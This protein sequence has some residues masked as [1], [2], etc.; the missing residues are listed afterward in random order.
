MRVRGEGPLPCSVC[1]VGE[2]PGYK[3]SETGRPFVG[4][5][6]IELTRYLER[7]W[8]ERDDIYVTNLVK[9][10]PPVVNGKQSAPSRAD[11]ER[12]AP[13]LVE[14]LATAQPRWIGAVGRVAAQWL[15]EVGSMEASHGM[16]FPLRDDVKKRLRG[17][18]IVAA[19][20]AAVLAGRTMPSGRT[21][22]H[23]APEDDAWIDEVRVVP[24]HHPAAALHN[25][26][27]QPLVHWDVQQFSKYVRGLLTPVVPVDDVS[28]P[29]YR[30]GAPGWWKAPHIDSVGVDTEGSVLR[31][32]SVQ[33]SADRGMGYVV[34]ADDA[35]GLRRV[36]R[37][38][39]VAERIVLQHALHDVDVLAAM[40]LRLDWR[41]VE[42]TYIAADVLRLVPRGLKAGARRDCGMEMRSYQEVIAPAERRLSGEWVRG[43]IEA[44]RCYTCWG[45]GKSVDEL[46]LAKRKAGRTYKTVPEVKC[47]DCVDG[48]LWEPRSGEIEYDWKSG[49]YAVR[50][51]WEVQRYLR[52]LEADIERG[53]FETAPL[54]DDGGEVEEADSPRKRVRSWPVE[55]RT[56]LEAV[57][58]PLPEPTLSDVPPDEAT[59]YACLSHDSLVLTERGPQKIGKLV[60]DRYSGHVRS[61]DVDTGRVIL[62]PVTGWYKIGGTKN[63]DRVKWLSVRTDLSLSGRWGQLVSRYT[64]DHRLLS[65]DGWKRVDQLKVG[66]RIATGTEALSTVEYQVVLGSVL[67]D[68]SLSRRNA[69][70]GAQFRTS[71]AADQLPY[72]QWKAGLFRSP[73]PISLA[74]PGGLGVIGGRQVVRQSHYSAA[75][76][77]SAELL[78]LRE[79]AYS[80][81][82][83]EIVVEDW[84]AG[85]LDA[86][87]L[88]VWYQDDGTLVDDR[89]ARI[90]TLA[91]KHES[92]ERLRKWLSRRHTV[93]SAT[94]T[95]SEP[96]RFGG[97]ILTTSSERFFQII[98]QYVHPCMRYKL[99]EKYRGFAF[100]IA[101]R[102]QSRGQ[103]YACVE[104][105]YENPAPKGR[106]GSVRTSYCIDVADTHNFVTGSGEVAHNC[107]D[108]DATL[109]RYPILR[110]QLDELGLYDAYRLDLDVMPIA[111]EMQRNGMRI[112]RAYFAELS[113]ELKERKFVIGQQLRELVGRPL[114]PGSGDQ[115]AD[116]LYGRHAASFDDT[117]ERDFAALLSFD[118]APE[119]YTRSGKRGSTDDKTLEGLKL[120]YADV[121]DIVAAITLILDYRMCDKIDGTYA[122]KLPRVADTEDR[123]HT[124]IKIGPA[125]FRWAS[126][127]PNLQN[128][129]TREKHG[130]DLGRRVRLGFEVADGRIMGSRDF[131]QVEMRVLAWYAQDADLLRA[132]RDGIDIHTMTASKVFRVP[133]D[134]VTKAQRTSAKNIGFGIV[135]GV[136]ARGLK[137][138]MEL[139]GLHWTVE[140]CQALIDSYLYE[141][142]PGVGEFMSN[143]HA[144][145]RRDGMVRSMMGHIRYTSAVHSAVRSISEEALRQAANFKI[146]CSAAELL[147]VSMRDLWRECE[148]RFR[149]LDAR[150]LMAV[151]DELLVETPDDE[152]VREEVDALMGA[153]MTNPV[154]LD[155]VEIT[156]ASK[157]DRSWGMLK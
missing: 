23:P 64:A 89:T 40:G 5:S 71:H 68:G 26:E 101:P 43:A 84:W 123:V 139:R 110:A 28:A 134:A 35:V 61:V 75:M 150:I 78:R 59:R 102:D 1:L 3:E 2:A 143:A 27:L 76:P 24:L 109:R 137:A 108:A 14:E 6:G 8:L 126:A 111:A 21:L 38:L 141:A 72:L 124:R 148:E 63:A 82:P 86:L 93:S 91:M 104:E 154:P 85:E 156:S 70:G 83:N 11:I 79:S 51:G 60:K 90:Y 37:V 47:P 46:K 128:I 94:Y 117:D 155:G 57:C 81:E 133:F 149:E 15:A 16:A 58:G 112:N 52:V 69:S 12:D 96:Y 19:R 36:Q 130:E 48:G 53:A 103:V 42:D 132:F 31:P 122:E 49:E 50:S 97:E 34:R 7:A 29:L 152:G 20:T 125:T 153:Y 87:A 9:L 118:L 95:A 114:N 45:R 144:E 4:K 145:A 30:L 121:A 41:R 22:Q 10:Q 146:Q 107:R 142:Y 157:W 13:E 135:Y 32:W 136:T 54:T 113:E 129:P 140:E 98:A 62:K 119:K 115:V 131:D 138:Q 105:V 147:K 80:G 74:H 56:Q 66:D 18:E 39:D 116:L 120:K 151:H 88:A 100:D 33:I 67:G 77:T 99:P 65:I 17:D 73:L 25:P 92:I 55:V 106:R 127:D 44:R